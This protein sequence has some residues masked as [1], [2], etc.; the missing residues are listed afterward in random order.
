MTFNWNIEGV[1]TIFAFRLTHLPVG[2][3][4]GRCSSLRCGTF[5]VCGTHLSL[6]D[7][8]GYIVQATMK[9]GCLIIACWQPFSL[10]FLPSM[11]VIFG[12][13]CQKYT[14]IFIIASI[15]ASFLFYAHPEMEWV[16]HSLCFLMV[17]L[18]NF[19]EIL[20]QPFVLYFIM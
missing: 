17:F 19:M 12:I 5:A 4:L 3:F 20:I 10:P 13:R 6:N 18:W 7:A 2:A 15:Y 14:Q 1:A 11:R 8:T 9:R 16:S